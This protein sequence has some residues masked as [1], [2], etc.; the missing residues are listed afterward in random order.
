[1]DI[2]KSSFTKDGK[3]FIKSVLGKE[4]L[5][6]GSYSSIIDLILLNQYNNYNVDICFPNLSVRNGIVKFFD[7]KTFMIQLF[8]TKKY[9]KIW[10][11]ID[12]S[13]E[14]LKK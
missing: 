6:S 4:V 7:K 13:I 14:K 11:D 5:N 3:S 12:Y 1:M 10:Y 2:E 8:L 9:L